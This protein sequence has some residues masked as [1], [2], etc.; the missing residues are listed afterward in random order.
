VLGNTLEWHI[1]YHLSN[2]FFP[3]VFL[4]CYLSVR[5]FITN[6]ID[7]EDTVILYRARKVFLVLRIWLTIWCDLH[8]KI[9][10]VFT[11]GVENSQLC[12]PCIWVIDMIF[13]RTGS[14]AFQWYQ[15][16]RHN[17]WKPYEI[18]FLTFSQFSF[19]FL[20]APTYECRLSRLSRKIFIECLSTFKS[21]YKMRYAFIFWGSSLTFGGNSVT[22]LHFL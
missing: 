14:Q 9:I 5:A 20:S 4:C 22:I 6:Y 18:K 17:I 12:T 2:C 13:N 19:C 16:Q 1:F 8:N 7:D 15:S 11:G 10:K 21:V 3:D